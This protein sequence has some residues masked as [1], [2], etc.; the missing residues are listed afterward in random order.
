MKPIIGI[1]SRPS[2]TKKDSLVHSVEEYYKNAVIKFGGIPLVIL[3]TNDEVYESTEPEKLSKLTDSEKEDL[4]RLL[5]L[6]DGI[7]IPGGCK[8]YEY[9]YYICK[10]AAYNNI[11]ILGICAGMQTMARIDND[12]CTNELIP[13]EDH[14]LEGNR[15]HII[16]INKDSMLYKILKKDKIEV[17]SYHRYRITDSGDYIVGAKSHNT[18]ESI[19]SKNNKFYLGVQWHPER[20]IEDENSKKIFKYFIN[21]SKKND[22]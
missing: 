17:N 20:L 9:D 11:P 10:Y 15:L 4:N 1:I 5:S 2:I 22:N 8:V 16:N 14:Y 19:E 18:I 7:L 21:V 13:E 6:L 3:P 12:N